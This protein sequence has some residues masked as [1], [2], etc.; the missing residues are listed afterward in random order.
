M[1]LPEL[2]D[3]SVLDFGAMDST[4]LPL[5]VSPVVVDVGDAGSGASVVPQMS[6]ASAACHVV[7]TAGSTTAA[8]WL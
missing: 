4:P 1:D 6:K 5:V 8:V 2:V 7:P 3:I